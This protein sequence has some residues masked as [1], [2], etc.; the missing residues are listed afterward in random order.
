MDIIRGAVSR[1]LSLAY[2]VGVVYGSW[3]LFLCGYFMVILM[4]GG[5]TGLASRVGD[6]IWEAGLIVVP[7]LLLVYIAQGRKPWHVFPEMA[8][9]RK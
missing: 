7:L 4:G 2:W 3:A 5:R 8:K 9:K 6:E 1:T